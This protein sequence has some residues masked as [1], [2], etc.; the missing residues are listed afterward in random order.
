MEEL[1]GMARRDF[2]RGHALL[3]RNFYYDTVI[4]YSCDMGNY[5]TNKTKIGKLFLHIKQEAFKNLV[6]ETDN[7]Y[8]WCALLNSRGNVLAESGEK[9]EEIQKILEERNKEGKRIQEG[10]N[11]WLFRIL[12]R[13]GTGIGDVYAK[14]PVPKLKREIFFSF[15]SCC[16]LPV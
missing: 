8:S 11:G 14:R 2:S 9:D 1:D 10:K 6:Y 7:G 5:L 12:S 16:L 15:L 3:S 4:T 13:N